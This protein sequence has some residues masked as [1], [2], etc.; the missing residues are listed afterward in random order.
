[1]N[2]TKLYIVYEEGYGS[3]HEAGRY[4]NEAQ[5]YEVARVLGYDVYE[6][7]VELENFSKKGFEFL[8]ERGL[9]CYNIRG[10]IKDWEV[11][12]EPAGIATNIYNFISRTKYTDEFIDFAGHVWATS[13][14]EAVLYVKSINAQYPDEDEDYIHSEDLFIDEEYYR[15]HFGS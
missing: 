5:A 12:R 8:K 13:E 11:T 3:F 9:F 15:E 14:D 2:Q 10:H 4:L 6:S 1:M 7:T